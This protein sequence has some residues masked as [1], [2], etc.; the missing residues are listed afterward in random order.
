MMILL[1]S[2]V[3]S[4]P[5]LCPVKLTIV[6]GEKARALKLGTVVFADGDNIIDYLILTCRAAFWNTEMCTKVVA[7]RSS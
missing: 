1:L 2:V 6:P 4:H 5:S 7:Y 3:L